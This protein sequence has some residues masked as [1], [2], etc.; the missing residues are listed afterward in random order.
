MKRL[1]LLRRLLILVSLCLILTLSSSC[2]DAA[3]AGAPRTPIE[4]IIV[5]A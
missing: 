2:N 5:V 4:H 3:A 1:I